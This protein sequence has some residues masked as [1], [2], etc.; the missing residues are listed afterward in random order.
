MEGVWACFSRGRVT[1]G[2]GQMGRG[3][4]RKGQSQ[5]LSCPLFPLCPWTVQTPLPVLRRSRPPDLAPGAAHDLEV[6]IDEAYN[7]EQTFVLIVE[8]TAEENGAD[9]VGH[10]AAQEKR[11][12]EGLA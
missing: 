11:G 5:S 8:A 3:G 7:G 10:G 12:V 1:R 2:R 4:A 6:F 9:D